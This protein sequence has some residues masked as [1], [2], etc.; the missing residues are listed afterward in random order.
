MDTFS[1]DQTDAIR[2]NTSQ[3]CALLGER[4]L[5]L[6]FFACDSIYDKCAYAITIPSVRLSV[7]RADLSKT[8]EVRI[9]Q[10]SPYSSIIL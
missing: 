1:D 8:V 3:G 6:F 10:F 2:Q 7:T 5:A 9:M 4:F